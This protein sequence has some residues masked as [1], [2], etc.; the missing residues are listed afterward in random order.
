MTASIAGAAYGA[1]RSFAFAVPTGTGCAATTLPRGGYY[2]Y[3]TVDTWVTL[4]VV[5]VVATVPA[6]RAAAGALPSL[7]KTFLV[8]AYQIVP[9][10]TDDSDTHFSVIGASAG[11]INFTG[12]VM[13]R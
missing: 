3:A 10:E 8:P 13:G 11:T 9:L 4:G 2:L 5:G 7:N 12:P 1:C 6:T